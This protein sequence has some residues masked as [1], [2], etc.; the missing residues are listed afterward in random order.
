MY[1]N[2]IP[3][4]MAKTSNKILIGKMFWKGAALQS[5]MHGSEVICYSKKQIDI[6]KKN[7]KQGIQISFRCNK[8]HTD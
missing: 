4:I 6:Y 1:A 5:I 8:K 3:S 7:R 2:N